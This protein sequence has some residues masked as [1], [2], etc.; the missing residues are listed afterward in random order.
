MAVH[1]KLPHATLCRYCDQL[2]PNPS[3]AESV[4]SVSACA[5]G[6]GISFVGEDNFEDQDVQVGDD[7]EDLA[8]V[9]PDC[10]LER[11]TLHTADLQ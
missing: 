5:A 8:D 1:D 10:G 6:S 4:S 11:L 3:Q 9:W 2:R 7:C